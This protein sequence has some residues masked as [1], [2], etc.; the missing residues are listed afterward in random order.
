MALAAL[1]MSQRHLDDAIDLYREVLDRDPGHFAALNDLGRALRRR[2]EFSDAAEVLAMALSVNPTD[3][4]LPDLIA[5][6]YVS[7]GRGSEA[8][9]LFRG[10]IETTPDLPTIRN[11]LAGLIVSPPVL[12]YGGAITLLREG[13]EL[14]PDRLQLANNLAVIM[15]TCQDPEFHRPM[16]AAV[17]MENACQATAFAE[18]H[19]MNTLAMVYSALFRFDEAILMAERARDVALASERAD[20]T[21]LVPTIGLALEQYK[22]AKESGLSAAA[23]FRRP[24][25]ADEPETKEPTKQ[26]S[27]PDAPVAANGE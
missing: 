2:G 27:T 7:L 10:Y 21:Q 20:F 6:T 1:A 24:Q 13:L 22:L 18:P 23:A 11:T 12:D 15:T 14:A 26:E 16:Q 8:I 5:Q 9:E 17:L 3:E 25:G 19:Y 4:S